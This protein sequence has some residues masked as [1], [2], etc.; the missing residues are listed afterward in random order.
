M[1][2]IRFIDNSTRQIPWRNGS[3]IDS[4]L[5]SLFKVCF[6]FNWR[7]VVNHPL[8]VKFLV[9]TYI[10]HSISIHNYKDK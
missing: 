9:P 2:D 3:V 1:S 6:P 5:N 8:M 10:E 4:F 7:V